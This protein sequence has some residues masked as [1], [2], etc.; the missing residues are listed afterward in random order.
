[1]G[2]VECQGSPVP[3][4]SQGGGGVRAWGLWAFLSYLGPPRLFLSSVLLTWAVHQSGLCDPMRRVP[5]REQVS[6]Q[7]L[8]AMGHEPGLGTGAQASTPALLCFSVWP[9]ASPCSTDFHV[10]ICTAMFTT[11]RSSRK[12]VAFAILA[13]EGPLCLL[14]AVLGKHMR[15]ESVTRE[16]S[17]FLPYSE[18]T[19]AT[20]APLPHP[21]VCGVPRLPEDSPG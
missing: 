19:A 18:L 17:E 11:R 8:A 20:C 15:V 2:Q 5:L 10:P 16:F 21:Q 13:H 6:K 14:R 9:R 1:M 4:R 7:A 12:P 3:A